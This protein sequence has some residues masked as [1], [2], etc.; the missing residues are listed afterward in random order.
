I[1]ADGAVWAVHRS[2]TGAAEARSSMHRIA[3]DGVTRWTDRSLC[4]AN[5]LF[6][7]PDARRA[8]VTLDRGACGGAGR[9]AE[10]VFGLERG[11]VALV[12]LDS[13]STAPLFS[14]L[15]IPNGVAMT[16]ALNGGGRAVEWLAVAET[17]SKR[18]RWTPASTLD[19]DIAARPALKTSLA[20]G[21]DNIN[22]LR[23]GRGGLLVTSHDDL[24]RLFAH[25]KAPGWFD[26]PGATV[27]V[28][29]PPSTDGGPPP[30]Q[31]G[32][33]IPGELYAGATAAAYDG[34]GLL[35]V[36]SAVETGLLVCDWTPPAPT[37]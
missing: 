26:P 7:S 9:M 23:D 25:M 11:G 31:T 13:G 34:D 18:I 3:A 4:R 2:P 12:D 37:G 36:G 24:M 27:S 16:A 32:L 30:A 10:E 15:D 20:G 22:A 1:A 28:I 6:V 5:D 14:G 19:A 21:P 8:L 17:R 29:W 33:K 35:V